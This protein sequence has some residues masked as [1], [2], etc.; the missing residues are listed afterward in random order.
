M[1]AQE[2][3]SRSLIFIIYTILKHKV[4]GFFGITAVIESDIYYKIKINR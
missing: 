4:L 1:L 3:T 2:L